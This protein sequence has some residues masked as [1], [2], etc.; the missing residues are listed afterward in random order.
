LEE[1]RKALKEFIKSC[2][3]G[4]AKHETLCESENDIAFHSSLL[5]GFADT[6]AKMRQHFDDYQQKYKHMAPN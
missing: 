4:I 6:K 1:L 2:K 3:K 5:V